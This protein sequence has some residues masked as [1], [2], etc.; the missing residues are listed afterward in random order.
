MKSKYDIVTSEVGKYKVKIVNVGGNFILILL[1]DTN[2]SNILIKE[3][4]CMKIFDKLDIINKKIETILYN[5]TKKNMINTSK[6]NI[7]DCSSN[8]F[9]TSAVNELETCIEPPTKKSQ[10]VMDRDNIPTHD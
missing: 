2:S 7:N 6:H 1:A 5:K 4:E 3:D 10:I 8:Y 9:S